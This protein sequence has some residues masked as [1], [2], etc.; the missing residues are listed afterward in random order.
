MNGVI[1][2]DTPDSRHEF[3]AEKLH[4]RALLEMELVSWINGTLGSSELRCKS[5]RKTMPKYISQ[6]RTSLESM[7]KLVGIQVLNYVNVRNRYI[8]S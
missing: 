8:N 1:S 3:V 2:I 7:S 6:T 4:R 5:S